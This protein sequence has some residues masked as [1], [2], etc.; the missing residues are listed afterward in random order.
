MSSYIGMLILLSL[1]LI[2]TIIDTLQQWT[3]YK[4]IRKTGIQG[5]GRLISCKRNFFTHGG[6]AIIPRYSPIIEF[7]YADKRYEMRAM[8]SFG[9]RPGKVGDEIAIIFSEEYPDKVVVVNRHILNSHIAEILLYL[10]LG[11]VI[12]TILYLLT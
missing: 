8:G 1:V 5:Y 10:A 3:I 11:A 6:I 7:C 12:F 4:K 9:V 2:T